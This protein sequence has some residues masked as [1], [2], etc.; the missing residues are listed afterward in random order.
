MFFYQVLRYNSYSIGEVRF[1]DNWTLLLKFADIF[2]NRGDN[3][4]TETCFNSWMP[5]P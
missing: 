4:C 3:Q 5:K 2:E 1:L